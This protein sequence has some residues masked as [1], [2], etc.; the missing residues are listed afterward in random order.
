MLD[1]VTL[2]VCFSLI[3]LCLLVLFYVTTYRVTRSPFSGWWCLALTL[4]IT[5]AVAWL[6][7]GTAAQVVANPLGNVLCVTGSATVWLA[8]RSLH[9]PPPP[10]WVVAIV[11]AIT[12]VAAA[13]GDPAHDVWAGGAVFLAAMALNLGFA[14]WETWRAWRSAPGV[15]GPGHNPVT[16]T[17]TAAS[18]AMSLY[19]L[20]RSVVFVAVGPEDALFVKAFGTTP[21]TLIT[22]VMLVTVSHSM[23][24]LSQQQILQE[25]RHR[26]TT[27]DLT[28]MLHR[29]A[30]WSLADQEDRKS[31]RLNSSHR[32]ISRMPSSA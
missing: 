2:R 3:A 30:F 6:L 24:A 1:S 20:G 4:F 22:L 11:P 32:Y 19:Y 23:G 31:T 16:T 27:D 5:A 15:G 10:W 18:A 12:A 26:A 29:Q 13:L 7:N 17:L 14:T 8:A 21:T 9:R 25:L 28:G